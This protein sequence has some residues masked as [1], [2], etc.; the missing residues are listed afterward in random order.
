MRRLATFALCLFA[1]STITACSD[2]AE[3]CPNG[4][5]APLTGSCAEV[6]PTVYDKW[7]MH[8]PEGAQCADGTQYRYFVKQRS[9]SEN[10]L[11][12]Y[13]GGGACWDYE[14][15]TAAAGTLGALGVDCVMRNHGKAD[16]DKEH[17]IPDRYADTYFPLPGG[18]TAEQLAPFAAL[19]PK[20]AKVSTEGV[21][22][23]TVLPLASSGVATS[24]KYR[25]TPVSPMNDW[26]LVFM[27]YCTSDLYVGNKV[28]EYTGPDPNNEGEDRTITFRHVGLENAKVVA[29]ELDQLFPNIPEFAMNGCSAGGAGVMATYHFFR[30]TMKGIDKS[31]VFSDAGPFFPTDEETSA[32]PT[33]SMPLHNAV[34]EAWGID[35]VFDMLI[36]DRPDIIDAAP[37]H[38]SDLYRILSETYP[39]DRFS[40]T[41]TQTDYNYS[42]YSYTSFMG[43]DHKANNSAAAKQVYQAW[44]EDNSNLVDLLEPLPNF[45]TFMPFWRQTN[46]SHCISL[47]GINDAAP[48]GDEL[49]GLIQIVGNPVEKYYSGTEIFE[50]EDTYDYRSHV[51]EVLAAPDNASIH[52]RIGLEPSGAK[53]GFRK[54]CT[55]GFY[56]QTGCECA[57]D[58]FEN[59]AATN[60]IDEDDAEALCSC[61]ADSLTEASLVAPIAACLP[62]P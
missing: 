38:V 34:R 20:W 42:L 35:S 59:V 19:I 1:A 16:A 28:A 8:E 43:L 30:S 39:D 57:F 32:E 48:S 17:C 10:L 18:I 56:D 46:D 37:A 29:A 52:S 24:G 44:A 2:D 13:E 27:P 62:Q 21:S 3:K 12:L 54:F 55:P 33:H 40:V 61:L 58:E 47:I 7:I 26:N 51:A 45:S 22:V 31:Y 50:G 5:L 41:H 23:D 6:D 4:D 11:V 49:D 15:C 9:E 36:A 53:M 14:T 60:S 25:G